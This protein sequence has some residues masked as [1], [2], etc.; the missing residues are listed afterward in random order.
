MHQ[1]RS[2][3]SVTEGCLSQATALAVRYQEVHRAGVEESARPAIPL[4]VTPSGLEHDITPTS[5]L[6]EQGMSCSVNR[7]MDLR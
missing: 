4:V 5:L 6:A 7:R 2:L 1:T 3:P